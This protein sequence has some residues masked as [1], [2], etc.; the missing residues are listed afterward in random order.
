MRDK[1]ESSPFLFFDKYSHFGHKGKHGLF[2][3][4]SNEF[5]FRQFAIW[6]WLK[7][8]QSVCLIADYCDFFDLLI[9]WVLMSLCLASLETTYK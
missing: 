4:H 9:W 2:V 7:K 6:G 3:Y 5:Y 8:Q 1:H